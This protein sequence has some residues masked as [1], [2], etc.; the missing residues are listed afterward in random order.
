[1]RE[2]EGAAA[3]AAADDALLDSAAGGDAPKD[4]DNLDGVRP[5]GDELTKK[6][7]NNPDSKTSG[8]NDELSATIKPTRDAPAPA[9]GAT[10]KK[11][12]AV[13]FAPDG[14]SINT[15]TN[16]PDDEE[17]KRKAA[18]LGPGARPGTGGMVKR[19]IT[20]KSLPGDPAASSPSSLLRALSNFGSKRA[21]NPAAEEGSSEKAA[22][23]GGGGKDET[24]PT[25]R[26]TAP[27]RASTGG[28]TPMILRDTPKR[29]T[30]QIT[31]QN[32]KGAGPAPRAI[33]RRSSVKA[34][35]SDIQVIT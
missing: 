15:P 21:L 9:L 1:M 26:F 4:P 28:A 11:P 34:I 16:A 33:R 22:G 35:Q 13:K 14:S 17:S 32:H 24:M 30:S 29:M 25:K 20:R 19:M 31:V 12:S 23:G 10:I 5:L 8:A 2:R 7:T 6:P 3:A 27:R 18:G